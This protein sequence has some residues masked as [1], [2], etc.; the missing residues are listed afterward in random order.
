MRSVDIWVAKHDDQ[1]IPAR[2][3]LRIWAREG[4]RCSLTGRKIMPGEPFDYEHRI[5]LCNGG[6]HSEDNIVLALRGKVHQAKTA[7]DVALKAKT[8]RIAKK[9]LGIW[10]KGQRIQSRGFSR[11]AP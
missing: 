10:P 6:R 2:V 9:H 1:A 5:A 8:D 4:G 7:A 3:K 11:R